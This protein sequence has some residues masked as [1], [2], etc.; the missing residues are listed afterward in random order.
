MSP[1]AVSGHYA[2]PAVPL[3]TTQQHKKKQRECVC[4]KAVYVNG[5][6]KAITSANNKR[7]P[8]PRS[9]RCARPRGLWP[10]YGARVFRGRRDVAR[11]RGT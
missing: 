2:R 9:T 7:E 3:P 11:G 5:L 4:A 1:V 6:R 10:I 8:E